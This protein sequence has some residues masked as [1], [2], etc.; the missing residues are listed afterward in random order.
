MNRTYRISSILL[1]L[2]AGLASGALAQD[3]APMPVLE[4]STLPVTREVYENLYSGEFT[5]GSG[6]DII[7][8]KRGSLNI[9]AYGL[10]RYLN[11][12]PGSQTYTDHLEIGRA[13]V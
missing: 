8:T 5:P 4:D 7:K 1:G 12:M 13:H 11:Q 3:E 6:F 10:F 2:V 9:S